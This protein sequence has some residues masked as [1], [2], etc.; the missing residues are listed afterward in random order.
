VCVSL[1][2]FSSTWKEKKEGV[3]SLPPKKKQTMR[4]ASQKGKLCLPCPKCEDFCFFN[5]EV[6]SFL[7]KG[8]KKWEVEEDHCLNQLGEP[9]W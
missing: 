1:L 7:G 9:A 3:S 8:G 2:P 5:F 6:E 4:D